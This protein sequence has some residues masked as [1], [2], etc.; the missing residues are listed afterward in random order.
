M[1]LDPSQAAD[2]TAVLHQL[3]DRSGPAILPF[4][5]TD[6]TIEDKAAKVGAG[7]DPVTE[8][9]RAAEREIVSHLTAHRRDDAILGEEFGRQGGPGPLEWVIDPIDGTRAFV[10][11]TPTWGTLIGLRASGKALIGAMDQPFTRERFWGGPDGSF[12]R[13]PDGREFR[14][15]TA[16]SRTQLSDA[17][18]STTSP[19]LFGGAHQ[20]AAFQA[21]QSSVRTTRYGLDCYA[22]CLLAGGTIDVVIEAGLNSYDIVALIPIIEGAGGCISTWTGGSAVDGGDIVATANKEL[23]DA[24]LTKIAQHY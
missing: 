9:D 10:F 24:V 22:Y 2:L 4:F 12:A 18:L 11:G 16:K 20:L 7:F 21:V 17:F 14:L 8:A 1:A 3:A 23:H 15:S 13:R 6:L 5:R 19:D